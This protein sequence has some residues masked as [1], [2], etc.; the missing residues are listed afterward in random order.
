VRNAERLHEC[1]ESEKA[2]NTISLKWP[3]KNPQKK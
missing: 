3:G 2:K 1:L